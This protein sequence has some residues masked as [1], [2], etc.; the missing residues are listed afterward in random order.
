MADLG[1]WIIVPTP[2]DKCYG[3]IGHECKGDDKPY[4]LSSNYILVKNRELYNCSK[5]GEKPP[6]EIVYAA[7][8]CNA[9]IPWEEKEPWE[10][11]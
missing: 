10:K 8:L 4:A 5:C 7:L 9:Y 3:Q 11:G 1:K 6:D 2:Y